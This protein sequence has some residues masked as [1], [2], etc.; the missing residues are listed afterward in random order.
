MEFAI[1]YLAIISTAIGSTMEQSAINLVPG[2]EI[3]INN[4]GLPAGVGERECVG[5]KGL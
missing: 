2:K 3:V 5:E 1:S 4:L